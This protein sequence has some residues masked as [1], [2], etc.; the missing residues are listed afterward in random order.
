MGEGK[1]SEVRI[2]QTPPL[3]RHG[4]NLITKNV[5]ESPIKKNQVQKLR[6][7]VVLPTSQIRRN[8]LKDEPN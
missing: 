5:L 7:Y 4:L 2:P 8:N 6:C 3:L 1:R